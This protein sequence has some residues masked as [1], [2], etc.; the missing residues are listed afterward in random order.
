MDLMAEITSCPKHTPRRAID[1]CGLLRDFG[2][3]IGHVRLGQKFFRI[4]GHV[5]A[6][7]WSPVLFC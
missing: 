5:L 4:G 6:S 2:I 1:R 7:R 3:A